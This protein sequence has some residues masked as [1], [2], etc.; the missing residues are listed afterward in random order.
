MMKLHTCSNL[1][2]TKDRALQ[3]LYQ[4]YH[5]PE[6]SVEDLKNMSCLSLTNPSPHTK[7]SM[8]SLQGVGG[9][10]SGRDGDTG[11][12]YGF[13]F[14]SPSLATGSKMHCGGNL[15]YQVHSPPRVP[16]AAK[17][18][19][20]T[21][22][23]E[24]PASSL[25]ISK[26]PF[27]IEGGFDPSRKDYTYT[28]R[29]PNP[30]TKIPPPSSRKPI[31][32]MKEKSK[33]KMEMGRSGRSG[34]DEEKELG[35]R[36][37]ASVRGGFLQAP[38]TSGKKKPLRPPKSSVKSSGYGQRKTAH[39]IAAAP[40]QAGAAYGANK[41]VQNPL[42]IGTKRKVEDA[43]LHHRPGAAVRYPKTEPDQD[44]SL[45]RQVMEK[46]EILQL[47]VQVMKNNDV[48]VLDQL[49]VI[50]KLTPVLNLCV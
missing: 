26:S 15:A 38:P 20:R 45:L 6:R 33:K 21:A 43:N 42:A 8:L 41:S 27:Q 5:D 35:D 24:M 9:G 37:E 4:D 23:F 25:K 22:A 12:T 10:R 30:D 50:Y 3:R 14:S 31:A 13:R 44:V 46:L 40:Q 48:K 7:L 19:S 29:R 2:W 17:N 11:D 34:E 18:T 36:P 32:E 1:G 49:Q 28:P 39:C 47:D 16:F